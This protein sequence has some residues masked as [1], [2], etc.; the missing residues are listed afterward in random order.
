MKKKKKRMIRWIA[1]LIVKSKT[2]KI[3]EE[4][5]ITFIILIK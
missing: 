3:L 1:A 5:M 2:I 4:N